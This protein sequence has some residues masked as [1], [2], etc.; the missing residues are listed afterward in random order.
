MLRWKLESA[1]SNTPT[2]FELSLPSRDLRL[3]GVGWVGLFE[4]VA[5]AAE[6]ELS[7]FAAETPKPM[8]VQ[9]RV[10]DPCTPCKQNTRN[11]QHAEGDNSRAGQEQGRKARED[12]DRR[13]DTESPSANTVVITHYSDPRG[14]QVTN[15]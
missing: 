10:K 5:V 13:T 15:G 12:R 4:T 7:M 8:T 6:Q 9:H 11:E 14:P 1:W 3:R 2:E